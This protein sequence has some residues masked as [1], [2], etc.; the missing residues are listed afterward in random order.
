MRSGSVGSSG[1]DR[2]QIS[3]DR[4]DRARILANIDLVSRSEREI[5]NTDYE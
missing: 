3:F 4:N 5:S 1:R 2:V